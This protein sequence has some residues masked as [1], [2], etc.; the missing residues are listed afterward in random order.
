NVTEMVVTWITMDYTSDSIVEYNKKGGPLDYK[1]YGTVTK[2]SVNAGAAGRTIYI[3]RVTMTGLV[4]TQ[5]YDYHC[6]GENGWSPIFTFRARR[7]GTDW[8]PKIALYGDLGNVNPK[9]LPFLQEEAQRGDYDAI[10]HVGDMAYNLDS[11]NGQVGDEFMRQIESIA[12][13]VPYMTCPGNHESNYN[14]SNYKL[15]LSMPGNTQSMYYSWN[16]GPAHIVSI[17][18]EYYFY[19]NLFTRFQASHQY[20]WLEQDLKEATSPEN[21]TLRPWIITMGHRPMYCSNNDHDDCTNH[22]SVVRTGSPTYKVPGLE[23]LFYQYG[24]DLELWAHEHSY[25]RLFPVYKRQM[26]NGS[27]EEPYTNPCAPVHI[28]TGSAGCYSK[29]DPFKPYYGP[30]TAKRVVDYGYTRMNIVNK[31]HLYMEQF[32]TDQFLSSTNSTARSPQP[33]ARSP[34]PAVRSPHNVT[35]MVVTWVTMDYTSD[36]IVEYNKRGGPLDYKAHGTV[37]LFVDGGSDKRK[38]Y[39]HRV[40]LTGLVPRVS[41]DYHCGGSGGWSPIFYFTVRPDGVNWSPRFA[42]FGDMGNKN[43]QSVPFLQEESQRGHF[44]AILHVTLHIIWIVNFSN[45]R[46]RFTMPGTNENMYYSINI[47]PVH[48][49]SFSTEF[50]FYWAEEGVEKIGQQYAWLE[51]DLKEAASPENRTLRPWI[52]T[53][54][55]R[56]MYCSN[57]DHDDCT[58]HESIIRTGFGEQHKYALEGL[59]YEYGVDVE[60]WAHEHSYERLFPVYKR[61]MCNGS[62]EEPYT[63][64]CAPVHIITGSAGCSEIH[65]HFKKYRGPWTAFRTIDYGYTRMQVFNDTHLYV[66]QF[67]TNQVQSVSYW[68]F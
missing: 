40:T 63:N 62:K 4:P 35:E 15:R 42:F 48:I 33:A 52:I 55:H 7:G 24:V 56:P 39:M 36:S 50:Y 46:K 19:P 5:Y 49:I 54:A 37:D 12:A 18:T 9:S 28:I 13:Y 32:S 6:G 30:W 31:T 20:A 14:F 17:S 25:E 53:M 59:F 22:E 67:S 66:E 29:H 10:L 8:T 1:A 60:L 34:Q 68:V 26:C 64:P 11:D 47:G 44:D 3:H 61:Q 51:K 57:N 23:D 45:Y 38:I 21:R 41:Y 58:N 27:K 43:A 16:I 65:D 2:Y